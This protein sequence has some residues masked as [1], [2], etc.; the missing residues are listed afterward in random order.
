MSNKS[1]A[2]RGKNK[3]AR[4]QGAVGCRNCYN[5]YQSIRLVKIKIKF[6]RDG[7]LVFGVGRGS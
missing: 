7:C 1:A 2:L 5:K 6:C 4:C 3:Y